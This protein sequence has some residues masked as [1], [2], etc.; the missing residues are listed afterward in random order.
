MLKLTKVKGHTTLEDLEAS[1][2]TET[3]GKGNDHADKAL[4]AGTQEGIHGLLQLSN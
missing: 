1:V 3:K 4:D 2:I